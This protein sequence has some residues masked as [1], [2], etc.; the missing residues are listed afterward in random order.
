[1]LKDISR[2]R[3][4]VVWCV[5]VLVMAALSVVAG[6]DITLSNAGLLLVAFLAPPV[7]MLLVWRGAP[8][9][10]VAEL[11][12]SVNRPSKETRP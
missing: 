9:D 11:L 10:T 3:V 12:H 1:M 7:V 5:L 8:P 2:L 6:A 4:V